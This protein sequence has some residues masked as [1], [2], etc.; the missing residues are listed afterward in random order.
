MHKLLSIIGTPLWFQES[1]INVD[2]Y[3]RPILIIYVNNKKDFVKDYKRVP[4]SVDGH[5]V[6]VIYR[7]LIKT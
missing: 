6:T 3:G 2:A 4:D 5:K 7:N 1:S